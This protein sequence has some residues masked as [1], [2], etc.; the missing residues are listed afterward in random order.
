VNIVVFFWRSVAKIL[1][2]KWLSKLVNDSE[3][4]HNKQKEDKTK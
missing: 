4:W 1:R 3:E 2:L